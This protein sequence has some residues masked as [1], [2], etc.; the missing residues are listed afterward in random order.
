MKRLVITAPHSGSGKTTVTLGIMAAL[1]R[2]GLKVAPFKVGP[3]FIDPGYHR[4]VTGVPSVNLDGWMCAPTFLRETFALHAASADVAVIEGV[5][6]LFDG[7][8]GVSDAGSTAQVAKELAAPVVLVVDAK[9]QARSAAALVGGFA[10]FDPAVRVAAVIFNNVASANHERILR[11]AL[12]AHLP[13]VPVVGC[14]PRDGALAI[15]SRHLGLI[16]AEDNP[17]S[18]EFLDHLVEVIE[19]HL[20]LELLLEMEQQE[21]PALPQPLFAQAVAGDAPEPVRIA[22]A[23]DAA[24]CFAYPD[25]LRLLQESGSE[26]CRFSPLEDAGLPDGIGGIYLPGG[27]PELFA[28]KL[29]ANEPMKQALLQAVESGMPVYAECGGFIYLTQ[30]V[31]GDE[32]TIPFVDIFPVRTR[33]LPRRKALGYREVELVSRG[34]IGGEGTVARGH[35]FHYSEMEE[36]PEGVERLYRV[37]R[38]GA[39][40]GMEGYRYRN[41][42]ASYIHLHFGSSPGIARDFVGHCRAYR[43][44]SLT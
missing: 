23:S 1:L 7:I 40:L 29:A 11:E 18:P 33:M 13:E 2:R 20:D 6:G 17:L 34:I 15:P 5:M 19:R 27:Y 26:I 14:L 12:G 30:G 16:T 4:L 3:D 28:G 25:N 42:L 22:V 10:G 9:S 32:G 39:Y 37:S 41:C 21:L 35:E 43:T 8:D 36:M 38:K 31:A 24:F 44:R